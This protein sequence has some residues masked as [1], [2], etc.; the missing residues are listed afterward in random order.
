MNEICGVNKDWPLHA[1]ACK[2]S[3]WQTKVGGRGTA[4]NRDESTPREKKSEQVYNKGN[5][6]YTPGLTDWEF[7]FPY[8]ANVCKF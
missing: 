6:W 4:R 7:D 3:R 2:M 1:Y 5:K 8:V